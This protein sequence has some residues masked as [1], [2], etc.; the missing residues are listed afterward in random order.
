MMP[1]AEPLYLGVDGGGTKTEAWIIDASGRLRGQGAGGPSNHQESGLDAAVRSIADALNGAARAAGCPLASVR[2]AALGLA[3]A[4]FAEDVEKLRLALNPHLDPVPYLVVNDG[5]IALRGGCRS[6]AGVAVVAGT[7]TNVVGRFRDGETFQIGGLGYELGDEGGGSDLVRRAL[8]L[9]FRG[10][11]GRGAPTLLSEL[12]LSALG[13]EDF[14]Q[15]SRA[16]YFGRIT[17]EDVHVLAPLVFIAARE[18]DAVAQDLLCTSG[19]S[20]GETAGAAVR[21]I[22]ERDGA[23]VEVVRVG[24]LWLGNHPLFGDGF[25][26]GLHRRAPE[27]DVHDPV[28]PPTAGAVL[29]AAAA[30][31]GEGLAA[32]IR[33]SLIHDG[34]TDGR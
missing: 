26:V 18:G 31:G 25:M 12:A 33:E 7:G 21:R 16:L 28:L 22:E 5:D 19:I 27:A 23:G 8:H 29:M 24:S 15:L 13:V 6:G 4:D 34:N 9:A 11:E 10:A 17:R 20:L 2:G 14:P 32:T 1:S 30:D 3:G